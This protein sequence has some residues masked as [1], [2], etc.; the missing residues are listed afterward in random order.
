MGS[1]GRAGKEVLLPGGGF[2]AKN[3]MI[4]LKKQQFWARPAVPEKEVLLPGGDFGAKNKRI[5]LKS[6]WFGARPVLNIKKILIIY[7]NERTNG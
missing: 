4:L 7:H 3:K 1:A 6:Q 5:L 2:G